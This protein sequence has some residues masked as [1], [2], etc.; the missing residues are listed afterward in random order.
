MPQPTGYLYEWVVGRAT[1]IVLKLMGAMNLRDQFY[2]PILLAIFWEMEEILNFRV[3]S[4][5]KDKGYYI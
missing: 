2:R 3:P 1:R 5:A 4:R